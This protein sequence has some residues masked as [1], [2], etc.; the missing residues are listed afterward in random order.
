MM[1][2]SNPLPGEPLLS[3]QASLGSVKLSNPFVQPLQ[4]ANNA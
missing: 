2:S 1:Q 3:P 4:G